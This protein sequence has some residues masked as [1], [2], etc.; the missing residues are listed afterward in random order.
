MESQK[1]RHFC[2]ANKLRQVV[3]N[4]DAVVA[5][6]LKVAVVVTRTKLIPRFYATLLQQIVQID[7]FEWAKWLYNNINI[8]A[9][10]EN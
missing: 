8:I 4:V 3:V 7:T 9:Q 6:H 5:A 10:D 1:N 2:D